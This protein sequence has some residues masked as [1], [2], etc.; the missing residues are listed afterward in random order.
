MLVLGPR[1]ER[2]CINR[3]QGRNW[4]GGENDISMIGAGAVEG[5]FE[6]VTE[7]SGRTVANGGF[8]TERLTGRPSAA[9]GF[10]LA[11]SCARY[12]F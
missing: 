10:T 1:G 7:G 9:A 11:F 2:W 8:S 4:A 5:G 6:R 12:G 3:W